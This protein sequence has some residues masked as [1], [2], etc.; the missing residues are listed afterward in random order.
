MARLPRVSPVGVPIH[1]IQRGNNREI[2][3]V[4]DEDHCAYAGWLNEYSQKY[5]VNIHAWVM[6]TSHVHLLCTPQQEKAVSAM[7]QALGRRYVRY[8]NHEYRRTG[9]LWEGRYKSCLVQEELYLMQLYR[10]IEL[11]PV[12]AEMV[13]HPGEY[14][15]SSYSAN[16]CG[17]ESSLC[18]PHSEYLAL[19][20]TPTERQQNYSKLFDHHIDDIELLKD[21]RGNTN[22]GLAIGND[23]FKQQIEMLTGRRVSSGKRGRPVGWRKRKTSP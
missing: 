10:Y 13:S 17:K 9:T 2:C 15:W 14:R 19:G 7:M 12:R 3:F 1:L 16:A 18:S 23:R 6:M 21:I 20:A 5:K 4:S 8:F 11:N 22:K